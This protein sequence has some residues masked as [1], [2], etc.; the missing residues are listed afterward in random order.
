MVQQHRYIKFWTL[1]LLQVV[2]VGNLQ[3]LPANA[4]YGLS[5]PFLYVLAACGF[6]IPCALMTDRLATRYPQTGGAYIWCGHAFGP[7]WGFL[8]VTILWIS[9]LL[10]YPSIF[11]LI[12]AN[13]AYLFAPELAEN[14][15]FIVCSSLAFYWLITALN[16]AGVKLSTE[17]SIICSVIGIILPMLLIIISACYWWCTDHPVALSLEKTPWIPNLSNFDNWSYLIAIVISLF[18]LEVAAVHSGNVQDPKKNFP[19]S[20]MISSVLI[21]VLLLGAE[22]GIAAI[23]P[24][25]KL[26]VMTGLLDAIKTFFDTIRLPSLVVP[27]LLIVFL[28]NA[29]STMAWMLGSTRGMFVACQDNHVGRFFQKTNRFEAPVGVLIIEACIFTVACGVFLLF[30]KVTDT[31]W[32]LLD[33]ASAITLVYY[34]I[35]FSSALRLLSFQF[36]M[37][38]GILTCIAA[39][40]SGFI[41]PSNLSGHDRIIFLTVMFGGLLFALAVPI[42]M[43]LFSKKNSGES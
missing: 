13:L 20:L 18:G 12:S 28:G 22:L 36:S 35:L 25:E 26:S 8:T 7:K 41:P 31:F 30:P 21:L 29:G 16:C 9:N 40:V 33:L 43:L 5:L 3:I 15:I 42:L 1:A 11:A 10:W 24:V 17:V 38:L 19:L 4:T 37:V 39:F 6:F 23:I 14:T 32:L 2:I 27:I 34:V